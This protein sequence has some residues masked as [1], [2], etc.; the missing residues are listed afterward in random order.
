MSKSKKKLFS[1]QLVLFIL[2]IFLS[3]LGLF[4]V[5][6]AS[7]AESYASFGHPYHFVKQQS[8]WFAL[9]LFALT[10]ASLIPM[11]FWK[12][13]AFVWYLLSLVLLIL[14]FIPG[15]G[16]EL[17]GAKRWFSFGNLPSI[18]P[19]E[20]VKF[21]LITF[22][23]SWMS[24][25]QRLEP[26]LFLT[27]IPALLIILQPDLGSL[28][29][30]LCIAFGLYFLAG[31]R[32]KILLSVGSAGLVLLALAI[33]TSP[34]RLKRLKTFLNPESDPLGASFHIR[35]ITLALG[36][37]GLTGQGL[38]NSRQRFSYIPEA[39]SDSIFAII[40]EEIGF[41]GC[42]III[43]MFFLYFYLAYKIVAKNSD[44]FSKLV[45]FG[46]ILWISSQALLNLAAI[47]A[48]VPLTGLPLPFFSY[49]GSSL[50]MVLFASGVLLRIAK[51]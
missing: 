32:L 11:K 3:L 50:V 1:A 41:I 24:K 51:K 9:G 18:Q 2:T 22:F 31:G 6:E 5:F 47:V 39:A 20:F 10:A 38:G 12:K 29:V 21:S 30:L 19:I 16:M 36:S 33:L 40:A 14:V 45:G 8:M 37:G 28:L 34:Y 4:F 49:G 15:I 46:I 7:I 27:A 44:R 23:A 35:Q 17:N 42:L 43:L 26:F 13:T 25:H 48:L